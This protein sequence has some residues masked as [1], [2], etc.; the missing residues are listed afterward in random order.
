MYLL[1]VCFSFQKVTGKY[2]ARYAV[3]V[4][5]LLPK[6]FEI[7]EILQYCK[8]HSTQCHYSFRNNIYMLK[9][10]LGVNLFIETIEIE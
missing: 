5:S 8:H 1:V 3:L 9:H 2:V 7:L 6:S 10:V 4:N